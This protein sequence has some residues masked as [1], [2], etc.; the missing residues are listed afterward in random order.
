MLHT[1]SSLKG[2]TLAASDGD[3]GNVRDAYFDS[4]EWTLRYLVVNTGAWLLGRDVLI[5][6]RSLGRVDEERQT[7]A[8]ELTKEKVKGAP[9]IDTQQPVS[10]QE[11]IDHQSYYGFDPYWAGFSPMVGLHA[12]VPLTSTAAAPLLKPEAVIRDAER[13]AAEKRDFH[14]RSASEVTGYHVSATDEEIGHVEDFLVDDAGWS[15]RYFIVDTRNWWAGKKVIVP[16]ATIREVSWDKRKVYLT[17]TRD[18]VRS[19]PEYNGSARV[20][21]D[22]SNAAAGYYR[23]FGRRSQNSA[24]GE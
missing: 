3:I 20:E 2:Y 10:R 6:P 15:I 13:A 17:I 18:E 16:P 23:Q 22:Y 4:H 1:I 12:A 7:I 14:L 24:T 11:E 8:V 9:D 21:D 19:A 5:S